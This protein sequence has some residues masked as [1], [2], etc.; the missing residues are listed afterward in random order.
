MSATV[1]MTHIRAAKMCRKGT[2]IFFERHG[3]DWA[4]FLANGIP[5]E[6]L[7]STGDAMALQ[8]VRIARGEG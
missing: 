5:A 7:A 4:D 8:V 2:R 6:R 1:T 3:F